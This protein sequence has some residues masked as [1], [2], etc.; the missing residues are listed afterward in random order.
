M[1]GLTITAA[2]AIY[3]LV[4]DTVF[5][6][7]QTL[8]GFGVDEAFDTEAAETAVVELGVDG[9]AV[10]GWVP[11]LTKQTITLLP[12]SIS[13]ILFEQWVE[14]MD[15]GQE[16]LY[17]TGVIKI[18]AVKRQYNLPQGTLTRHP[19]L[20]NAK[21]VLRDRQF[22]ITWAWPITMANIS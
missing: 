2:T 11:R 20:P 16:V 15:R 14:A 3:T 5:P 10:S 4:V 13:F 12:S 6:V 7:P 17:A 19:A 22:E 1:A 18:P 21:R 9:V 8:Q